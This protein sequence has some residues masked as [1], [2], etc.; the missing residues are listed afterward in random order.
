MANLAMGFP[1]FIKSRIRT[2]TAPKKQLKS[3]FVGAFNCVEKNS[4]WDDFR[5]SL[6]QQIPIVWFSPPPP[7]TTNPLPVQLLR[8]I[9]EPSGPDRANVP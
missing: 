7:T 6:N 2:K 4:N 3:G 1:G 5:P 8:E 9:T